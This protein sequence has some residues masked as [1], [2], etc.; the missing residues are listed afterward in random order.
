LLHQSNELQVIA[1]E[2]LS[3]LNEE[4]RITREQLSEEIR[5]TRNQLSEILMGIG[6]ILVAGYNQIS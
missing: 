1:N 4:V 6:E 5:M 2:F 3:N